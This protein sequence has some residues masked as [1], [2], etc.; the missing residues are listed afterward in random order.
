MK[1]KSVSIRFKLFAQVGAILLLAILAF[2]AINYWYLGDIYISNE[3]K[4]MSDLAR[5]IEALDIN[6]EGYANA[7]GAYENESGIMINVYSREGD[8]LYQSAVVFTGTSGRLSVQSRKEEADGGYFEIQQAQNSDIQ[9]IVYFKPMENGNEVEMFSRK[10]I[11]DENTNIALAFMGYTSIIAVAVALFVIFIY[12][13]RF[14]R[15]LIKMSEVTR[16]M[17]KQDFSQM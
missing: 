3:M 6:S 8:R 16:K 1:K 15:P 11:I 17:A 13:G 9:Y 4:N 12:S 14:T 2:L 7:V 5:K 10:S